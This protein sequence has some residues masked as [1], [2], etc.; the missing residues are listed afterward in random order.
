MLSRHLPVAVITASLVLLTGCPPKDPSVP[1]PPCTYTV[2]SGKLGGTMAD[3]FDYPF[4]KLVV[5]V[6]TTSGG[7]HMF[8]ISEP[9]SFTDGQSFQTVVTTTIT[10]NVNR[11]NLQ[12][13]DAMGNLVLQDDIPRN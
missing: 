12:W 5:T 9:P 7:A 4:K 8:R 13:E 1:C 10:S 6:K 2:A 11:V 3:G